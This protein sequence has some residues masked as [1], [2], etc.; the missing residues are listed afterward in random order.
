MTAAT[1]PIAS[2]AWIIAKAADRIGGNSATI[3][4]GDQITPVTRPGRAPSH[5]TEFGA[6]DSTEVFSEAVRALDGELSLAAGT[7]VRLLVVVSD[8]HFRDVEKRTG[9]SLITRLMQSG[10]VVLWLH[11]PGT[12]PD[13]WVPARAT[14]CTVQDASRVGETIG[15]IAA[16]ALERAFA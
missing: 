15:T 10:C 1:G 2:A 3:T 14:L 13:G 7:G 12:R 8:G 9:K 16:K 6:Y 4:F 5:V 11:L